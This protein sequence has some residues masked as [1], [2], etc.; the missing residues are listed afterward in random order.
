MKHVTIFTDGASRG[1]PGPGGWGVVTIYPDAHDRM[2]VSELGGRE[3]LTTNNRMEMTAV[4]K[5]LEYFNSFYENFTD[6]SFTIFTDSAYVL[7]GSSK[8]VK[9]W[10]ANNWKSGKEE[11]KN[12]DIWEQIIEAM[13]GKN[14]TWKLLPGHSGIAGNERCDVISTEFADDKTVDLY[15]GDLASYSVPDIM[16]TAVSLVSQQKKS[17]KSSSSSSQKAYSYVSMVDGNVKT[18]ATWSECEA[19]VKGQSRA[20][21]K[22]SFSKED[23]A[24]IIKEFSA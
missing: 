2:R 13:K 21:F 18:H 23:E 9:G 24:Q 14:I 1:N 22:K 15:Q 7:N 17:K 19:R 5:G 3:D 10:V 8:W 11:V 4:L 6:I 12:R 20:R 16:N